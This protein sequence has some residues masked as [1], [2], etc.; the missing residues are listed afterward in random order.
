MVKLFIETGKE[1]HTSSWQSCQAKFVGGEMD[2]KYLYEH[3]PSIIDTTW[4]T[5]RTN[6]KVV[7]TVYEL[8]EGTKVLIDYKG[9]QGSERFIIQLDQAVEVQEY[10]IGTRHLR[11][12]TLKG[13]YKVI[14]NLVEEEEQRKKAAKTDGF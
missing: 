8:P 12:Y 7:Q 6:A 1:Q 13:R 4:L 10:E 11:T 14:R 3:K 2:G 5:P 9:W